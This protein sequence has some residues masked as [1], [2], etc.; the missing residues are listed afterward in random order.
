MARRLGQLGALLL[1][2]GWAAPAHAATTVA[3]FGDSITKG[4][5]WVA[6]LR[7]VYDTID[8]GNA[9]ET[10]ADGLVRLRAWLAGGPGDVD[11]V[12]LLEGTNDVFRTAYSEDET[13][14]RL[15]Q[16]AAEAE[17]AGVV[18]VVIAPPPV[19]EPGR[20]LQEARLASLATRLAASAAAANRRFVDLYAAFRA[21]PDLGALYVSDGVHPNALGNAVIE[22]ALRVA[23]D[24]CPLHENPDQRDGDSDGLGDACQCGDV[25]GSGAVGLA[26]AVVLLRSLAVPPLAA[27][28]RP[29]L[30]DVGGSAGCSAADAAILL[31]S[32]LVPAR[33]TRSRR[34]ATGAAR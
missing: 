12:T 29:D 9:G 26:D 20:E 34:C 21:Q 31:R 10:T 33:A 22:A 13:V 8:M 1:V 27:M 25:D 18:P 19:V 16:M 32:L 5:P 28:A 30:C 11:V 15:E 23:L 2:V 6:A 3:A 4:D 17:A 7:D 24:N 14:S